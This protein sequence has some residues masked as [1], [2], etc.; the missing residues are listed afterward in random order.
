ML[1]EETRVEFYDVFLVGLRDQ[2]LRIPRERYCWV[3]FSFMM[4]FVNLNIQPSGRCSSLEQFGINWLS[5]EVVVINLFSQQWSFFVLVLK[6]CNW[7][8]W[9]YWN[10]P[11]SMFFP[12]W[13][14]NCQRYLSWLF[15][16]VKLIVEPNFSFFL[17]R[18]LAIACKSSELL[19]ITTKLFIFTGVILLIHKRTAWQYWNVWIFDKQCTSIYV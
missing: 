19:A 15:G 10:L 4:R 16:V 12:F 14:Q 1:T 8:T 3:I 18:S 5:F 13:I 7:I 9:K 2:R 6:V 11:I 17:L